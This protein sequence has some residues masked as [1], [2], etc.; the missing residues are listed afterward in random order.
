MPCLCKCRISAQ[1][2]Q[3]SFLNCA[4]TGGWEGT[5]PVL[6][7][8]ALDSCC[9]CAWLSCD[10]NSLF[11]ALK[12]KH[13]TPKY[14][15]IYHASLVGQTAPKNK[16][17]ISRMLAAKAS[18]CARVDA[19]GEESAPS[20][21]IESRAMVE[22]RVRQCEQNKVR[23]CNSTCMCVAEHLNDRLYYVW[24]HT[25]YMC[26]AAKDQWKWACPGKSR[27][28]W[29]ER[30]SVECC[31][32]KVDMATCL[33]SDINWAAN[34]VNVR[35]WFGIHQGR[36]CYYHT[37]PQS[38]TVLPVT[39]HLIVAHPQPRR[40]LEKRAQQL[41]L[42]MEVHVRK[43]TCM[44]ASSKIHKYN[45]WMAVLV[46]IAEPEEKPPSAK[47]LKKKKVKFEPADEE[48][49]TI[50]LHPHTYCRTLYLWSTSFM[51]KQP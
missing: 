3:A 42:K 28:V 30:V 37:G 5:L 40:E 2:C 34:W 24:V 48:V 4:D 1:P 21:G 27:E 17:K 14:G 20:I 49:Q 39:S 32:I 50:F 31:M 22:E 8:M 33:G 15:L 12:T 47:K 10:S 38:S 19:L 6:C 18:L 29:Y 41:L 11:R 23:W 35:W 43:S 51:W 36:H 25:L 9:L 26:A 13:D 44:L 16:G 7:G 45:A 46:C